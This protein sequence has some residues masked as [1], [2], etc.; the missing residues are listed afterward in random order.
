MLSTRQW[1]GVALTAARS[2]KEIRRASGD[3]HS[4]QSA[5]GGGAGQGSLPTT[6]AHL[7]QPP[8][9]REMAVSMHEATL[10]LH[11]TR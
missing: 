10:L 6:L 2:K 8:A 11:R 9:L 1:A 5:V 4:P 7:L 3:W